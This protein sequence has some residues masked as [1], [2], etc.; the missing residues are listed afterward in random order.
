MQRLIPYLGY[1]DCPAAIRFLCEAFGFEERFRF[2]MPDGKIGHAELTLGD[3]VLMLATAWEDAGQFSPLD[4]EGVHTI[5]YCL[6]DDVD[7]HCR[8]AKAGGAT[9]AVEPLEE[10]GSRMYRALDLEGHRW[11]FASPVGDGGSK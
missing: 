1:R 7:A 11:I 5:V 6:V 3:N 2:P 8:R 10:H 9:I 4:L